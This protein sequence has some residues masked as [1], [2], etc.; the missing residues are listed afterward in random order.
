[1]IVLTPTSVTVD[2]RVVVGAEWRAARRYEGK[3]IRT[4]LP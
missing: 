1:L 3:R 4:D 2:D